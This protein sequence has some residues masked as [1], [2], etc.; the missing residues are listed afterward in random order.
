[1]AMTDTSTASH[2]CLSVCIASANH[3]GA[4]M[5]TRGV[6]THPEAP[7]VLRHQLV[8]VQRRAMQLGRRTRVQM[9][10]GLRAAA[11]PEVRVHEHLTRHH[12]HDPVR[13]QTYCG[14][15]RDRRKKW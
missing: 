14:C 6:L 9:D 3:H 8:A 7:D 15:S 1:M 13:Y 12:G 11:L 4:T 10:G 2:R 5:L